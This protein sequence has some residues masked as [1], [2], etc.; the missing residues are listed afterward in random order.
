MDRRRFLGFL[1]IA[2]FAAL[3]A[4]LGIGKIGNPGRQIIGYR[5]AT[6]V[7]TGERCIIPIYSHPCPTHHFIDA[8]MN[9]FNTQSRSLPFSR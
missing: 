5:K 8:G 9:G 7:E 6:V 1:A 2:P 3:A 4:K